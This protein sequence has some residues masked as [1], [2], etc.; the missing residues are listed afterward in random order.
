MVDESVVGIKIESNERNNCEGEYAHIP[1]RVLAFHGCWDVEFVVG[2]TWEMKSMSWYCHGSS[3]MTV[4][5]WLLE[6]GSKKWSLMSGSK[7]IE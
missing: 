6:F 4:V 2:A 5:A 1:V 7:Q 3:A